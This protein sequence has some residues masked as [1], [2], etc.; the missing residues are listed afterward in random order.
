VRHSGKELKT[1]F[2]MI[3]AR[4]ETLEHKPAYRRLVA[5]SGHRCLILADGWYEWQRPEDPGQPKRP[6][7]FSITGGELFCFAGLWTRWTGPGGEV[8]PRRIAG[9]EGG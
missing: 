6:L 3:N 8:V 1:G 5:R 7:H 9:G 2:S 4:A